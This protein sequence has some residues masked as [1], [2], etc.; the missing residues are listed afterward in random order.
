MDDVLRRSAAMLE[1]V[2]EID[3]RLAGAGLN[4]VTAVAKLFEQL[5]VAL[6]AIPMEEI[7]AALADI[8]R[9]RRTLDGMGRDLTRLRRLKHTLSDGKAPAQ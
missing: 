9:T 2:Q 6:E 5:H 1:S 8:D 4:G 3:Q 7:D